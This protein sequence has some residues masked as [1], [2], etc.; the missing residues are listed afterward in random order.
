MKKCA[1]CDKESDALEGVEMTE[2]TR[3]LFEQ[4]YAGANPDE[5]LSQTGICKECLRLSPSDRKALADKAIRRILDEALRDA[6]AS[7]RGV[8]VMPDEANRFTIDIAK[9]IEQ[10]SFT[11]EVCRQINLLGDVVILTQ[12]EVMQRENFLA[13]TPFKQLLVQAINRDLSSFNAIYLLLR[14]E[15]I[16][17]AAALVRMLCESVITLGYIAKDPENRVPRFLDYYKVEVYEIA[18]SA[19]D[20]ERSRAKPVHVDRMEAFLT[21]L[22]PEYDRVKPQY[23]YRD[24]GN[25]L[26]D[27]SNWCNTNIRQQAQDC[28]DDLVRLYDIVYSQLSAYVHGSEFSLRHQIAYS[29]K[30]YD[31]RIVLVDVAA[32]VRT[33]V[34]VWERWARFCDQQLG[35]KLTES[36]P[37]IVDRL[38]RLDSE[39]DAVSR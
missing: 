3:A 26:R 1:L 7:Q 16:H 24:K 13:D 8:K 11:P 15:W 34:Y 5:Y 28:G 30:N 38:D 22:R 4:Q 20:H 2:E 37:E 23:T 33:T 17:Q 36:L 31:A 21:T 9:T 18:K 35:W 27:F 10:V 12:R 6:L 19:L 29:L 32:V 25:R 39:T 14:C